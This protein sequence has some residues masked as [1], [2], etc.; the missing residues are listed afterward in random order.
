MGWTYRHL[1]FFFL[2]KVFEQCSRILLCTN[3]TFFFE[4]LVCISEDTPRMCF[5]Y[6]FP[7]FFF[8][9]FFVRLL[10]FG[11]EFHML[12]TANNIFIRLVRFNFYIPRSY[13]FLK[14][15]WSTVVASDLCCHSLCNLHFPKVFFFSFCCL[16]IVREERN[17]GS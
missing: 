3:I 8:F 7:F 16:H 17:V 6:I 2:D 10:C 15:Y 12:S 1:V 13:L 14:N 9:V 5:Y 11:G 4:N